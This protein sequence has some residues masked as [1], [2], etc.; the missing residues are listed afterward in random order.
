[1]DVDGNLKNLGQ[2]FNAIPAKITLGRNLFDILFTT[3]Q[4]RFVNGY[5]HKVQCL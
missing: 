1:M 5:R 3:L 2:S 4:E